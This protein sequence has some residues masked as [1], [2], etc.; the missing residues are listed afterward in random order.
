MST[1]DHNH[2]YNFKARI[3][4]GVVLP[5]IGRI[6]G[7]ELGIVPSFSSNSILLKKS[8]C[9]KN[10]TSPLNYNLFLNSFDDYEERIN[11]YPYNFFSIIV[12]SNIYGLSD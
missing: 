2:R 3:D 1:L 10:L 5:F 12:T 4:Y 8:Q 6:T 9:A 7:S 11:K